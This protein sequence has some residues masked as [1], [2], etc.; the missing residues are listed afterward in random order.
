MSTSLQYNGQA[1]TTI[2]PGSHIVGTLTFEG[3]V[4]IDG[5]VEGE[6]SAQESVVIGDNADV[7]AQVTADTIVV[8]GKVTGD[9]VARRR[10]EMRTPGQLYGNVKT[11]SLIIHDG[12][13]FQGQCSMGRAPE[14]TA[15]RKLTALGGGASDRTAARA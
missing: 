3:T 4:R 2:G 13:V 9:L 6:I 8:T 12:V 1:E 5:T 14:P 15:T 10:V 11:P 7:K